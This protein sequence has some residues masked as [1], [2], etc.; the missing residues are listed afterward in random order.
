MLESTSRSIYRQTFESTRR[1]IRINSI[2]FRV[3]SA[4]ECAE[5]AVQSVQ[6]IVE[7]STY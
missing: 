6:K 1:R 5:R 4:L 3:I 2:N 7:R